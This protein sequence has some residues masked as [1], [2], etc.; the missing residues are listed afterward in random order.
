MA[1]SKTLQRLLRVLD[2]KEELRRRELGLAQSELAGFERARQAAGKREQAGR[3][4]TAGGVERADLRDRVAGVEEVAAG[5]RHVLALEPH[6]AQAAMK[7]EELRTAFLEARVEQRQTETLITEAKAREA[8]ETE[9]RTQRSLDDM[10]LA[11]MPSE[12]TKAGRR[13]EKPY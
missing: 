9:R 11:R 8:A 4:L 1:I 6:I 7:V 3:R 5:R 2:M 10:Y 12:R 13:E